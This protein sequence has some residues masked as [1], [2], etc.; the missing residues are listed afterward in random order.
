MV[1][2]TLAEK[3]SREEIDLFLRN[4]GW[5]CVDRRKYF[6]TLREEAK[7]LKDRDAQRKR[8]EDAILKAHL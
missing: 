6:R 4:L 1:M 3:S 5:R 7:I 8:R 2:R